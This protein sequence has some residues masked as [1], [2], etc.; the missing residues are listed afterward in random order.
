M[1]LTNTG[2]TEQNK[3]CRSSRTN[4]ASTGVAIV[5]CLLTP[6]NGCFVCDIR[7]N[8][9]QHAIEN[10]LHIIN[11]IQSTNY[12]WIEDEYVYNNHTARLDIDTRARPIK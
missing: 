6:N 7:C 2:Q 8:M 1:Q 9:T 10:I 3:H 11:H 4:A 12:Q 5:I